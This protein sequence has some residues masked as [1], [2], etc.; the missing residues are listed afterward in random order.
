M[1]AKRQFLQGTLDILVLKTLS[2]GAMHGYGIAIWLEGR[3]EGVLTI[4]EGSLYPALHRLEA[5]GLIEAEWRLTEKKRRAKYYSLTPAGR[6]EL[7]TEAGAWSA[8][9]R[10]VTEVLNGEEAPAW[11]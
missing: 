2:W 5:R 6:R 8:F 3:T 7:A 11:A 10:A 9:A 1:H 4:E